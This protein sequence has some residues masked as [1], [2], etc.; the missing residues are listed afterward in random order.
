MKAY[1]PKVGLTRND[2]LKSSDCGYVGPAAPLECLSAAE[3]VVEIQV[4]ALSE[5]GIE[6]CGYLKLAII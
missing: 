5:S 1:P 4:S 3:P 2:G 6:T